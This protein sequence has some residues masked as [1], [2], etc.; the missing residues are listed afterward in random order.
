MQLIAQSGPTL[1]PASPTSMFPCRWLSA[2]GHPGRHQPRRPWLSGY[3]RADS[4]SP[5][6]VLYR[7]DAGTGS[8]GQEPRKP[9]TGPQS[10][11]GDPRGSSGTPTVSATQGTLAPCK[12]GVA[13][14]APLRKWQFRWVRVSKGKERAGV[15]R[16]EIMKAS[17]GCNVGVA[18]SECGDLVGCHSH[19]GSVCSRDTL[20]RRH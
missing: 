2:Q 11:Q 20:R 13:G 5:S 3:G 14:K 7:R 6:K 18:G 15:V 12:G 1:R 17:F 8:G 10:S 19:L 16:S 4:S 9:G